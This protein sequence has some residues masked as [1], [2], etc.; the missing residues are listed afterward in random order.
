MQAHLDAAPLELQTALDRVRMAVTQRA[1]DRDEWRQKIRTA[2]RDFETALEN[3]RSATEGRTGTYAR[4]LE[5]SLGRV[6][7]QVQRLTRDHVRIWSQV[8][9]L[10]QRLDEDDVIDLRADI[11]GLAAELVAHADHVQRLS[12]RRPLE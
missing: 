11:D 8:Q 7:A 10:E 4:A 3:H 6:Q 5:E 2:L 1:A 9:L 12:G